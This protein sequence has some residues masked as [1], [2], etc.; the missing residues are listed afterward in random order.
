MRS[1]RKFR[2]TRRRRMT[3]R[4]QTRRRRTNKRQQKKGRRRSVKNKIGVGRR[5]FGGSQGAAGLYD[6]MAKK[7]AANSA[8]GVY[9]AMGKNVAANSA[10]GVYTAMAKRVAADRAAGENSNTINAAERY[11]LTAHKGLKAGELIKF[12]TKDGGEY[13]AKVPSGKNP[14]VGET[15]MEEGESFYVYVIHINNYYSSGDTVKYMYDDDDGE[16]TMKQFKTDI[17]LN[18]GE[19]VAYAP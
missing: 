11:L 2:K 13:S 8:A 7:V 6:E 9:H 19:T 14:K 4:Q 5:K 10:A 18:K 1:F 15:V 17:K 16:S 3:K 12:T